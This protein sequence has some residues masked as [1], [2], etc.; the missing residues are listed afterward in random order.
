[1]DLPARPVSKFVGVAVPITLN[2]DSDGTNTTFTYL[3]REG[4]ARNFRVMQRLQGKTHVTLGD[5]MARLF[6]DVNVLD[7]YEVA[8]F[9]LMQQVG[10]D[11]ISYNL[12]SHYHT[13]A[14]TTSSKFNLSKVSADQIYFMNAK[15]ND[16]IVPFEDQIYALNKAGLNST[17]ARPGY[18]YT[19]IPLVTD[20]VSIKGSTD[21]MSNITTVLG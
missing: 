7:K 18:N 6:Y 11:K 5:Y 3:V 10:S 4:E 20:H 12:M 17:I 14:N 13:L 8:G 19:F 1:M 21:V 16:L 2:N 15:D 9:M